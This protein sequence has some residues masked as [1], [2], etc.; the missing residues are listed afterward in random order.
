MQSTALKIFILL[1]ACFFSGESNGSMKNDP[2]RIAV[3][4]NFTLTLEKILTTYKKISNTNISVIPGSTGKHFAQI[5]NGAPFDIF[6][7]ADERRPL[8]LEEKKETFGSF[9]Y[10]TG[11]LAFWYRTPPPHN[12]FSFNKLIK[13]QD[14]IAIANPKLAPYGF[15]AKMVI[16]SLKITPSPKLIIGENISQVFH[17]I[18]SGSVESGF[19]SYSQALSYKKGQVLLIDHTLHKPINQRAILLNRKPAAIDF[20]DFLQSK[21]AQKIIRENGYSTN[22][23]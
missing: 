16:D 20:F 6:L 8:Q 3:A 11:R 7:A 17:F 2:V 13:S 9:I 19:I 14:R 5:I 4:S 22:E 12:N 21:K 1:A 15:A 18:S 23:S 10:A